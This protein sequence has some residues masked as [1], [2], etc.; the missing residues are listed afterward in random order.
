MKLLRAKKKVQRSRLM[1]VFVCVVL[2]SILS[3]T[4]ARIDAVSSLTYLNWASTYSL[5]L[6]RMPHKRLVVLYILVL[7]E[8]DHGLVDDSTCINIPSLPLRGTCTAVLYSLMPSLDP[9]VKSDA[10]FSYQPPFNILAFL[11][12]KPAS[13][14]VSPRALH[15]LNV[16][17]IRLTSLPILIVIGIYERHFASGQSLRE[18]GK[19]AAQSLF[20]SLPRHIKNMP[21]VEALVGS[22]T[23]DLYE[24]IFDV[25]VSQDMDLFHGSEDDLPA[26][27]SLRSR[28]TLRPDSSPTPRMRR[29]PSNTSSL[30]REASSAHTSPRV[31][32]STLPPIDPPSNS[33]FVQSQ[34]SPL[35]K[36][37]T[38]TASDHQ[39]VA[40]AEA[41]VRRVEAL[42]DDIRDLPVHKLKDEMKELQ[43]RISLLFV[44]FLS[45]FENAFRTVKHGSKISFS[46]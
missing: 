21:L 23:N 18:S 32:V 41:S 11:I 30:R 14:I 43:V 28:D 27:R 20:N 15:T 46:L 42:L 3:N 31:Q 22:S 29:Q 44:K 24:A 5:N 39:T 37:F 34:R 16:F 8:T 1:T 17:L 33:L 35:A 10:L 4:V 26:L 40:S 13:W 7:L 45:D 12:L 19:G 38:R 36:L 9:S 25:E 6:H 2:I